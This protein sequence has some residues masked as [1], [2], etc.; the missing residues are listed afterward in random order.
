M[1]NLHLSI[2]LKFNNRGFFLRCCGTFQQCEGVLLIWRSISDLGFETIF[3]LWVVLCKCLLKRRTLA[4]CLAPPQCAVS[5]LVCS[6]EDVN[7]VG[8]YAQASFQNTHQTRLSHLGPDD[9][10]GAVIFSQFLAVFKC[11]SQTSLFEQNSF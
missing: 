6:R 4:R 1:E 3:I 2:F 11:L 5:L 9:D 8:P 10:N 7:V